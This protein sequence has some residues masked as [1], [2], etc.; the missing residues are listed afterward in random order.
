MSPRPVAR[1]CIG[2]LA[3]AKPRATKCISRTRVRILFGG[4]DNVPYEPERWDK[5]EASARECERAYKSISHSA[6]G[7]P[8]AR[9]FASVLPACIQITD[10]LASRARSKSTV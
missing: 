3:G 7:T 5:I 1:K 9:E 4:Y 10:G 2:S 8:S 6:G